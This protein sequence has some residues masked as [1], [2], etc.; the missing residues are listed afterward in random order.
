MLSSACM[1]IVFVVRL[2]SF[3]AFLPRAMWGESTKIGVGREYKNRLLHIKR[4]QNLLLLTTDRLAQLEDHQ[5]VV[6]E[7]AG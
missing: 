4:C 3:S 2:K 5:T 1:A 6:R 7:V